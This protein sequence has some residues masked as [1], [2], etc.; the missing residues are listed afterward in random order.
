[1][2]EFTER[3][4]TLPVLFQLAA[5]NPGTSLEAWMAAQLPESLPSLGDGRYGKD[6]ASILAGRYILPVLDGLDEMSDPAAGL[7]R[8]EKE[9]AGRPFILT[10]RTA[11]FAAANARFL[12]HQS[13]II[14]LQPLAPGEVAYIFETYEPVGG[15]LATLAESLRSEPTGP[16]ATALSTPLMV[17]LARDA[18]AAVVDLVPA[19]SDPDAVDAIRRYLLDAF[20]SK[21]YEKESLLVP[22]AADKA[23][24]YLRFLAAHTDDAGRIAWWRLHEAVPRLPFLVSALAIATAACSGLAAAF[25]ALFD[26]PWIGFWIGVCAGVSGALVVEVFPQDDPRR[27][28]PRISAIKVP[29]PGE[30]A[31]I[32]GFGVMGG[33]ALAV[34]AGFLYGPVGYAVIGGSLSGFTFAVGRFVS[35]PNDP[36]KVVTPV[37]ML[38]ADGLAV[39]ITWL[40]GAIAGAIL[41]FYFG[42]AFRAGHR[43]DLAELAILRQPTIVLG[44]IG[45]LGGALLSST[46]LGLMA[47]GSS[48][49]GRFLLT[50]LWLAAAGSTPLR[51]MRFMQ[52][53]YDRGVLRQ[54]SGYYE[55]RHETL[56]RYFGPADAALVT[57]PAVPNPT[58]RSA[59]PAPLP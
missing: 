12:L 37:S 45:A 40:T 6:V 14:E 33:A 27:A 56:R 59:G 28:R 50:R 24:G 10:C 19:A 51:L 5:W 49:W 23:R 29:S 35:Q 11:D 4:S 17:S 42:Y 52:D 53:A 39:L 8:I 47:S 48:S 3:S 31:R 2:V 30:L 46:G 32:V 43:A 55:F 22:D 21:A 9:L 18:G 13:I 36:L 38:R 16:V 15:P 34:I 1:M 57:A 41:G 26:H 54:M 25:F 44:L 58:E 20:V 7:I